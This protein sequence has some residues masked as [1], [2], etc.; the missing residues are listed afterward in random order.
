MGYYKS[1]HKSRNLFDNFNVF[2]NLHI[3]HITFISNMWKTDA[4]HL[5]TTS[6]LYTYN[7]LYNMY[8]EYNLLDPK[9]GFSCMKNV[10]Y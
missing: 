3:T 8:K 10:H 4:S 5:S 2:Q 1:T 7:S 6:W 9:I